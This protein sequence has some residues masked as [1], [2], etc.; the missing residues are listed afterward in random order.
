MTDICALATLWLG[1]AVVAT[2]LSRG[3][4]IATAMSGIVVGTVAQLVFGALT[5]GAMQGVRRRTIRC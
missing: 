3:L 1:L 4:R 5:G 2:L